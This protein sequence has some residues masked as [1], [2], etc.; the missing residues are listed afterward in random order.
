MEYLVYRLHLDHLQG[1]R[2]VNISYIVHGWMVKQQTPST[3]ADRC[4]LRTHPQNLGCLVRKC[5]KR[6]LRM[7]KMIHQK[8]NLSPGDEVKVSPT[9]GVGD[10]WIYL[11]W[12]GL[13]NLSG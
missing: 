1:T 10:L 9:S 4:C 3:P 12:E 6:I 8:F 11:T 2:L 7:T 13:V 5:E